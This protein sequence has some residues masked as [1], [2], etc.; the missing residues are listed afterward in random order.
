MSSKRDIEIES[1]LTRLEESIDDL[2]NNHIVHL[3]AKLD[4]VLFWVFTTLFGFALSII[5]GLV[6]FLLKR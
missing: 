3:G 5:G 4:K 6:L 1:R 2:K